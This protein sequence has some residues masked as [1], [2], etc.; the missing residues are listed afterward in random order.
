VSLRVYVCDYD[1][2]SVSGL[3]RPF[4]SFGFY[5]LNLHSYLVKLALLAVALYGDVRSHGANK[6]LVSPTDSQSHHT[7]V[8]LS[9]VCSKTSK[10]DC[11][12]VRHSLKTSHYT[13]YSHVMRTFSTERMQQYF[14]TIF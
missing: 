2:A 7:L 3:L 10:R 5:P 6:S 13:A 14:L 8:V 4:L 1:R 11:E 9:H 12:P